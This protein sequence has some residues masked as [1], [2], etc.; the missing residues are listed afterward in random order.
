MS[1]S[2]PLLV[3]EVR[4]PIPQESI[5]V[6]TQ[7]QKTPLS[8]PVFN[9][10]FKAAVPLLPGS[11]TIQLSYYQET[12]EITLIYKVPKFKYFVRPVVIK[13]CDDDGQ[14]QGPEEEDCSM[15]SA[16]KRISL[17]SKL[18]QTFTAEKLNEHGLGRKTFL[19]EKDLDPTANECHV[20]TSKLSVKEAHAMSGADLWMHFARELMAAKQ[21]TKRDQCKWFAFM[22]FTRYQPLE[23][24]VPKSHSDV[25]RNTKGHTALG[26][27][28][29][30]ST[31]SPNQPR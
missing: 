3:G 9:G 13:C 10:V 16:Q 27:T 20:F 30:V 19:L 12:K 18:L 31:P 5:S 17:G 1:Y 22:S 23:G 14:L 21:F 7:H 29:S 4:P 15:E 11:N 25:L 26:E 28:L 8:W 24:Y 2:L 6:K